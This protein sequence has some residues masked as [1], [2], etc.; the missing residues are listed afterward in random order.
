MAKLTLNANPEIIEQAKRL[1][2]DNHTSVSALFSRLIK[3]L[4]HQTAQRESIGKLTRKAA[5]TIM[6]GEQSERDVLADSL[7][8]K[9]DLKV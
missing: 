8:D 2:A 3:A 1:A 9:Y 5:G 7:R 6:L 4:T